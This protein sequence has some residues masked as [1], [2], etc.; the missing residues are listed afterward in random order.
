MYTCGQYTIMY[1]Y[2]WTKE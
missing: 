2:L 1:V